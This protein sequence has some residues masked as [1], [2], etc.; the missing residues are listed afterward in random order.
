MENNSERVR[1]KG[2]GAAVAVL[3]ELEIRLMKFFFLI[4][5]D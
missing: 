5:A 2:A 3:E 1:E 4:L